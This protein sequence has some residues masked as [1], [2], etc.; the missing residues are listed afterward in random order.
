QRHRDREVQRSRVGHRQDLL[1]RIRD[2]THRL[3][4][5][6]ADHRRGGWRRT[7]DDGHGRHGVDHDSHHGLLSHE[8]VSSRIMMSST[9]PA[10]RSASSR[11]VPDRR[12]HAREPFV[13]FRDVHKAYGRKQVLRGADLTVYRGEVL[14]ILGGSGT[15]KSVT[16]RHMLGLEAPDSGRVLVEEEDITDLPEEELYRV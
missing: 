6:S 2:R 15:G 16:L 3:L 11:D 4:Q 7:L 8:A 13:E 10:D 14:V 5:R 9:I 1:L 12:S